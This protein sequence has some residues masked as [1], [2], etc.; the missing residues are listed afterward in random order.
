MVKRMK[1]E[2]PITI[3]IKDFYDEAKDIRTF[4]FEYDLNAKPGQFF[5]LWIPGLNEKPFGVAS[6]D[7]NGFSSTISNV[8]PFTNK[9]FE[10][11]K[12]AI[13]GIRGPYGKDFNIN[14]KIKYAILVGGG[15]GSAPLSFLAEKLA[16]QNTK[17]DFI[18]GAKTENKLVYR[19]RNFHKN[20][21]IH[22]CTDDGSFGFKGLS[23]DLFSK[24]IKEKN[25]D[26]V[27][28]CGP[29][30][31]TKKVI[32]ISDEIKVDCEISMDRYIKCGIG[33]CG[34]C[35][36]DNLGIR[37]CVEGPVINKELAKK[38][39]EFGK[40]KRDASGTKIGLN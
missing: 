7:K 18:I 26:F 15:Y 17:V 19:K 1:I 6:E 4:Y 36:V 23:T 25:P 38:I 33:I 37:M 27:Y 9:L 5:L 3:P 32:E 20:I 2:Q 35:S 12:G 13:V 21:E 34:Q 30:L 22:Y 39:Y 24:L 16:L 10:L 31:M 8:G 11:K 14:K 28:A 29:E 40:Y